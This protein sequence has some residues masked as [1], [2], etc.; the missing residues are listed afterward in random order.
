MRR[1][2][3][4]SYVAQHAPSF[5]H[6]IDERETIKIPFNSKEEASMLAFFKN[7]GFPMKRIEN[8]G[9]GLSVNDF[10]DIVFETR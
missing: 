4:R 10:G 1:L 5:L 7:H 2:F 3:T 9:F 8:Y 6:Q